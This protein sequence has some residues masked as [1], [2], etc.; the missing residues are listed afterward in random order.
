[1]RLY[2]QSW[3]VNLVSEDTVGFENLFLFYWPIIIIIII[4]ILVFYSFLF[5]LYL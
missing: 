4:D 2:V 1:M 3:E 5:A